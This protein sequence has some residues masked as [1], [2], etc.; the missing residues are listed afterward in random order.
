ML[1][2][3]KIWVEWR[4]RKLFSRGHCF[5]SISVQIKRVERSGETDAVVGVAL[6]IR[7]VGAK[8]CGAAS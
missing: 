5:A 6:A 8:A 2:D 1:C 4:L 7:G 3:Y